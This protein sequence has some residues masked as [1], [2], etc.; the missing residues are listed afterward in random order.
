[1][2]FKLFANWSE[3]FWFFVTILV[4]LLP[5]IAVILVNMRTG[6]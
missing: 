2:R 1:M 4:C 3:Q 6:F 5:L